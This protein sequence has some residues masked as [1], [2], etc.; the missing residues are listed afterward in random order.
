MAARADRVRGLPPRAHQRGAD[1]AAQTA[2]GGGRARAL[3]AQGLPRPAPVLDRGP[4]HD[5]ADAR[6]ADPAGGRPRRPGGRRRDGPPRPAQRPRPQPRSLLRHDLR[7]VRGRLHA[8]GRHHHPPGRHRGRQVPPRHRRHLPAAHRRHHPGQPGVQPQPPRVRLPGRRG[9][10]PGGPD[11]TSG[12]P[13]PPGH[14]RR[15][16]DRDPRRRLLP[17]PGRGVRDAQPAGAR[18]LQGRRHRPHHH[19]QPDR[20]HHR[21]RRRPLD[22][23]GLGPRE[24]LRR[25]DHPRQ[26]RRRAGLHQR[27]AA[28]VRVPRGV[29]PRRPDR[30]DRLPPLRPQRVRRARLH[31]A[32][33]VRQD[34]EPRSGSRNCGPTG[35][36]PKASSPARRSTARRRRCGT[37]S[38]TCTSA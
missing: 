17:G 26:R 19:Q 33:D 4:R 6:R 32:R 12:A 3:H 10:H 37:T 27:R 24:G 2:G 5:R 21:P 25:A 35:W 20:V 13:R 38:P 16:A 9:G 30:P 15:D 31:A 23:L 36:C 1:H 18:R 14:E 8:R 29:R 34:Q 22:P 11:L 28:G 7:R